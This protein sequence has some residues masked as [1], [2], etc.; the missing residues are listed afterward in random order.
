MQRIAFLTLFFGLVTFATAE[1]GF[2]DSNGVKI[3]Y[4]TA[5]SGEAVVLIHGWMGDS[6]MWGRDSAGNTKLNT[7]NAEGFHLIAL[8]CRG[9]GKS[10]KQYRVD[11]YGVEMAADVV[12]LLDHLKIG[13]AHLVGYS[14]GAFIAGKVAASHPERVRSVVYGGQAPLLAGQLNSSTEVEAFA[15]AV[16]E[17]EGLGPYIIEVTPSHRPK[18]TLEQANAYADFIYRGKDLKA[19]AAAGRSF[20]NLAVSEADLI[21]GKAPSLFIHGDGEL[22]A[23]RNRAN[24]LHKLLPGSQLKVIAGADHI[25]TLTKP[26]FGGAIVS[27]LRSVKGSK[28]GPSLA[29]L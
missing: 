8:D 5:G 3:H 16:E 13:K 26:E 1:E 7:S 12:R 25:T 2:F 10:G 21:K 6:S 27:F 15:K 20:G 19:L 18:P 17:G 29:Q 11:Q 4:V 22:A 24:A 23:T 14:M 28:A 9:H